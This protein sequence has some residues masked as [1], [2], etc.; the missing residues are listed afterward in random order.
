MDFLSNW[1]VLAGMG[2]ALAALI[3]VLVYSQM[4]KNDD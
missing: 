4:K 2:L 3:G 1:Y